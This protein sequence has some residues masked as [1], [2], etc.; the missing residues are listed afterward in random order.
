MFETIVFDWIIP[1]AFEW[2]V[3]IACLLV[4]I[5]LMR[6]FI[7]RERELEDLRKK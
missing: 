6:W 1:L 7:D 2:A 5:K 4:G 3:V